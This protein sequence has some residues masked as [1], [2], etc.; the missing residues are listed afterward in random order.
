MLKY[1]QN[2]LYHLK[3]TCLTPSGVLM[4]YCYGCC[5]LVTSVVSDSVWP[6]G[7]QLTS[8]LCPWDSPGKG[9]RVGS[10][11]LLHMTFPTH[12]SKPGLLHCRQSLSHWATKE[13]HVNVINILIYFLMSSNT[14]ATSCK[15]LTHW[16]RPDAG[17]DWGQEEKGTTEVEMARWHLRLDGHEFE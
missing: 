11:A 12:W 10:H 6:C 3:W 16:K 1:G 7:L 4:Y 9:T 2:F 14:L 8:L 13:A 15:E 5:G 17:R